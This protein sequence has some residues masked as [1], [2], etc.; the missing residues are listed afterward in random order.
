MKVGC[1]GFIPLKGSVN[2]DSGASSYWE[3]TDNVWIIW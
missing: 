3:I 2:R 1:V